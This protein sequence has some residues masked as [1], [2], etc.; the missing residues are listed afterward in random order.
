H[1]RGFIGRFAFSPAEDVLAYEADV[2][3]DE[4][5]HLFL[6]DPDGS[7]PRDLTAD[8]PKGRRAQFVEWAP[9]GKT[10][11]YLSNLRDEKLLDLY[12]H[13]LASGRSQ[14]LW[15]AS[16]ALS[17]AAADRAHRKFALTDTLSD[18]N[19]NLWPFERGEQ[20]PTPHSPHHRDVLHAPKA[21]RP[22]A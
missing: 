16:G 5:A 18:S 11:L 21:F 19:A 10:F 8:Y 7:A 4:L 3:G 13:D 17:V 2:G 12:E 20:R 6:T 22:D 14:L 15:M 1:V 9:D